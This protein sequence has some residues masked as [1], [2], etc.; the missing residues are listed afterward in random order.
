MYQI[1]IILRSSFVNL[2]ILLN[3]RISV[4]LKQAFSILSSKILTL[5]LTND[6]L[7]NYTYMYIVHWGVQRYSKG[8]VVFLFQ[9]EFAQ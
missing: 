3:H 7:Y 4:T 8:G 9:I 6:L 2:L 1:H 5:I